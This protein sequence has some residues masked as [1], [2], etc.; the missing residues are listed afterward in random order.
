MIKF[1]FLS[2]YPSKLLK[3]LS[4]LLWFTLLSVYPSAYLQLCDGRVNLLGI[5]R[6]SNTSLLHALYLL[7]DSS[8]GQ[9][10]SML[11]QC[12]LCHFP[13]PL[14]WEFLLRLHIGPCFLDR[15]FF[16]LVYSFI[17]LK[18]VLI[19]FLSKG[20]EEKFLETFENV[21]IYTYIYFMIWPSVEC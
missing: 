9:L 21:F 4:L 8:S 7:L 14:P 15:K 5:L 2:I 20:A 17:L 19:H 12:W 18:N 13:L 16:S 6:R 10:L 1:I 3:I 11:P